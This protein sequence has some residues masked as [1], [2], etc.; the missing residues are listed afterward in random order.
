MRIVVVEDEPNT[1][2]GI[3]KM[4]EKYTAHE[5][6]ASVC[7]G[8][9]GL[10]EILAL[11]PEAVITDIHMPGM[12][13]LCMVAKYREAG[14][15]AV[16]I[17]LTGYSEFEYAQRAIQLSVAEYLL[18]P[19][20]VEDILN[21][22]AKVEERL[23]QKESEQVSEQQ[24]LFSILAAEGSNQERIWNQFAG[25]IGHQRDQLVSLFLIQSESMVENITTQMIE[26]LRDSFEA[27]CLTGFFIF[28]LRVERK[29]LVMF[30]DGQDPSYLKKMFHLRVIPELKKKGEFL[31]S[32]GEIHHLSML[33]ETVERMKEY[34]SYTFLFATTQ[35]IDPD[36]IARLS[37]CPL[38]YPD[39]LEHGIKK[40]I[41]SGNKD[42]ALKKAKSFAESVI[43]SNGEITAIKSFTVRFLM[44]QLDTARELIGN[45]K[46]DAMYQ[47]L[48]NDMAKTCI[49]EIFLNN[50]WKIVHMAVERENGDVSTDNGMVLNVIEFIRKNYH[51]DISL[52][53]AAQVAGI[54][55]EYLSK[56]F[57]KEMGINFSAFLI[58]FRVSMAKK[59]LAKEPYKVHQ[60]AEMVGYKDTKYFNKVFRSVMG[61]SPTDYRKVL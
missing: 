38:E 40:D 48:L 35:I 24:L 39:Y 54:T 60:I 36:L 12:D 41:R 22:L 4:I 34:A 15:A 5:V 59:L 37:L 13:G 27:S 16:P 45:R 18:K 47:Y 10:K 46:T 55:P 52:S 1:R 21:V 23:F 42:G 57:A 43:K 29:I 56:L 28:R 30:L 61:V 9:T 11:K 53:E 26:A 2:N 33:K 32:Y 6:C 7:D 14:V 20:N 50:Y 31:I 8:E 58:E 17:V 44:A 51:R 3:I 49:R 19:L 25:R